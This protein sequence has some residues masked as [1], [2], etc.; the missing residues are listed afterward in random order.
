MKNPARFHFIRNR[1]LLLILSILS[2]QTSC[3][4][5]ENSNTEQANKPSTVRIDSTAKYTFKKGSFS[6]T[7]KWYMDREIAY[8]MGAGGMPWLDRAERESEERVSLL[9][10]NLALQKTDVVADIGAGSGYHVFRMAPKVKDGK[11]FAV[12]LQPEMLEELRLRKRQGKFSNVEVIEGTEQSVNLP[13]GSVDKILMVDVYHEFSYPVE[14]LSSMYNALKPGG[15]IY[16]IEY[17]K[18]DPKVPIKE[19]HKMSEAQAVKE[20][21]AN[22][23]K[24]VENIGNLPWQHCLVFVRE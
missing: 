22:G 24:F 10:K 17:R 21:E 9:L 2:I 23:F 15:Q 5:Q 18:E 12:D 7:G 4:G 14:M 1:F 20:Y 3:R 11:V 6:G 16:L 8:V 13:P 19:L